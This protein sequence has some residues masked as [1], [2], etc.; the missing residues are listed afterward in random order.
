MVF[1]AVELAGEGMGVPI[2]PPVVVC[3]GIGFGFAISGLE[4]ADDNA[5]LPPTILGIFFLI[6]LVKFFFAFLVFLF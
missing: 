5:P 3:C 2:P 1:G 4:G 6:L